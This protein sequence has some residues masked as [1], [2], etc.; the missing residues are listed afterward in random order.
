MSTPLIVRFSIKVGPNPA[1]FATRGIFIA[2]TPDGKT[3]YVLALF[4][5]TVTPIATATD[6]PGKPINVGGI[7]GAIAITP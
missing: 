2:I 1:R 3:A 6:T 4:P 5:G 7:P